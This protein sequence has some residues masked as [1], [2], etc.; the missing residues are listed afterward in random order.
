MNHCIIVD[1]EDIQKCFKAIM[2]RVDF[3]ILIKISEGPLDA[4][5]I[6]ERK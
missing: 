4:M 3:W 6:E 2:E 1:D 5:S